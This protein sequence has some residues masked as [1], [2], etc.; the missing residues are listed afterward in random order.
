MFKI[1]PVKD[2]KTLEMEW[3]LNLKKEHYK[4]H[5]CKYVAH[6]LGHEGRGSLLSYLMKE[7]L[8]TTLTSYYEDE[9]DCF[10]EI[11]LSIELTDKGL[12]RIKEII[13]YVFYYI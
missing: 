10:T 12:A 5:P 11:S 7:G 8:A 6:L 13:E 2:K 9:Y 3:I 1:Y 4:N